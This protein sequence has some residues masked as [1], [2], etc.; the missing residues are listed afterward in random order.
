MSNNNWIDFKEAL[1][2]QHQNVLVLYQEY[3]SW[4]FGIGYLLVYQNDKTD[5]YPYMAINLHNGK[6][7]RVEH[8]F[9]EPTDQER[10]DGELVMWLPIPSLPDEYIEY[11]KTTLIE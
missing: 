1:P 6:Y 5:E 3:G 9:V 8:P 10:L 11:T 4:H 7:I 2:P